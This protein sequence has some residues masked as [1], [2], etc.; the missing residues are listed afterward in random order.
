VAGCGE[1]TAAGR[2]GRST[3]VCYMC[4]SGR[5]Q[6][7]GQLA[8]CPGYLPVP[9][10]RLLIKADPVFAAAYLDGA[11]AGDPLIPAALDRLD[12][13]PSL[14]S[15]GTAKVALGRR[16][17]CSRELLVRLAGDT[18]PYVRVAVAGNPSCPADI[19]GR[20]L[21][22]S[23]LGVQYAAKSNPGLPRSVLAMWQLAREGR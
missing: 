12:A 17:D 10:R 11:P 1:L 3:V 2:P 9:V 4:T 20:L 8:R 22:D 5:D 7:I 21:G 14:R 13:S 23:E 19:L 18:D 16:Q 6:D 15:S